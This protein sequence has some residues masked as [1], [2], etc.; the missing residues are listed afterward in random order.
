M[1]KEDGTFSAAVGGTN[2]P[3]HFV[4]SQFIDTQKK[5]YFLGKGIDIWKNW[6]ILH[7]EIEN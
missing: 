7:Y 4:V 3:P 5:V 2:L 1:K 6:F